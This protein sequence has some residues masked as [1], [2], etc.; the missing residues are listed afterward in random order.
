MIRAPWSW[1]FRSNHW[2]ASA[3]LPMEA[4]QWVDLKHQLQGAR[5]IGYVDGKRLLLAD[6]PQ[7]L[8]EGEAGVR[9][10]GATMEIDGMSISRGGNPQPVYDGK[11][12]GPREKA[13]AALGI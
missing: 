2:S 7:P 11:N 4:D 8:P 9:V 13:L 3:G 6:D 10:W 5:I 12:W 1:S